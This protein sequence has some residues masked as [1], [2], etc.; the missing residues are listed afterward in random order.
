MFALK[1]LKYKSD[2]IVRN[3]NYFFNKNLDKKDTS[4]FM[5]TEI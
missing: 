4:L 3:K 5:H 1:I 2:A